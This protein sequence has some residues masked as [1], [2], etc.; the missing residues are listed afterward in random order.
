MAWIDTILDWV[1][2][3]RFFWREWGMGHL[4]MVLFLAIA[5]VV[6]PGVVMIGIM[7]PDISSEHA[8]DVA[9]SCAAAALMVSALGF[10]VRRYSK[11]KGVRPP[12]R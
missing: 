8:W 9:G 2:P 4:F 6:R 11:V 5:L 7:D 12:S 1:E 10:A 3:P